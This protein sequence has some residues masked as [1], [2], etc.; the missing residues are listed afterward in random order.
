MAISAVELTSDTLKSQRESLH[1]VCFSSKSDLEATDDDE[2]SGGRVF[3]FLPY[4]NAW[5]CE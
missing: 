1:F 3:V 5:I 2:L 4:F